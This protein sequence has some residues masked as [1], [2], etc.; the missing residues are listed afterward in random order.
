M[1]L[2]W[3]FRFLSWGLFFLL[4]S[5]PGYGS[6]PNSAKSPSKVASSQKS[7]PTKNSI[8]TKANPKTKAVKRVDYNALGLV[9]F[10]K[11]NYSEALKQFGLATLHDAKNPVSWFNHAQAVVAISGGNDPEDYCDDTKNWIFEALASLSKSYELSAVK[12]QAFLQNAKE[13]SF[14]KFRARPEFKNWNQ[15][16]LLPLKTDLATQEFLVKNNDWL[17]E[18]PPMPPT[19]VT[20]LPSHELILSAADGT[21]ETGTWSAGADRVVVQTRTLRTF[22]LMTTPSAFAGGKKSFK[23]IVLREAGR[24]EQWKLG[25]LIADC[26]N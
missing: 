23:M 11:K 4:G 15:V 10:Q 8:K 13:P 26:G 12:T 16:R 1:A 14:Q 5:A 20:F 18:K 9:A 22:N 24:T 7:A 2:R 17:L 25:P 19:V 21:R 6:S 3:R